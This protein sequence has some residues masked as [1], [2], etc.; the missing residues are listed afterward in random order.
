M[1][2]LAYVIPDFDPERKYVVSALFAQVGGRLSSIGTKDVPL[3]APFGI[4]TVR[5]PIQSA[6]SVLPSERVDPLTGVFYLLRSGSA[7]AAQDTLRIGDAIGVRTGNQ[8]SVQTRSRTFFYNGS[9]PA[10]SLAVGLPALLEEYWTYRPNKAL[11]IAYDSASRWTY[12]YA[13]GHPSAEAAVERALE[14]CKASAARRQI[15]AECQV[16][17]SNN[18]SAR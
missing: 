17:V 11:A 9:G 15:V 18:E 7:V 6:N 1:A 10:R 12:G 5:T 4:V 8:S 3:Q 16:V 14:A 2:R 13:Y